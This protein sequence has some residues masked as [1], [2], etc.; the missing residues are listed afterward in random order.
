MARRLYPVAV[1][2]MGG[3]GLGLSLTYFLGVIF[4]FLPGWEAWADWFVP[5]ALYLLIAPYILLVVHLVLR[6]HVG[7]FLLKRRAYDEAAKYAKKRLKSSVLRS[8][9][10]V[11][12]Q[13]L[14]YA[15]GL[16]GLGQYEEARQL[17]SGRKE[18]FPGPYPVEA[19]RWLFELALRRNDLEDA[20]SLVVE[21]RGAQRSAGGQMAALLACEAELALRRGDMD[22]YKER[23]MDASWEK[24]SHPRVGLCRALAMI[25]FETEDEASD[26]VLELLAIA[27]EPVATEIPARGAEID[28]LRALVLRRRGRNEEARGYLEQAR[29]GPTDIWTDKVIE[30]AS[31]AID[32]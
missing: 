25:E 4:A 31:H 13:R 26:E 24:A 21:D 2:L 23:L 1:T 7:R 30:E 5:R 17:L 8:R 20:D 12:N 14:V 29:N 9:R 28:A 10:E 27:A 3:V 15:R 11:A 16:V 32:G 6:N 18:E 19:Q 22:S